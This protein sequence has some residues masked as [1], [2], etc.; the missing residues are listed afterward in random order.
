MEKAMLA[1]MHDSDDFFMRQLAPELGAVDD[2]ADNHSEESLAVDDDNAVVRELTLFYALRARQ[3]SGNF[4]RSL[5]KST[6]RRGVPLLSIGYVK[7]R[8]EILAWEAFQEGGRGISDEAVDAAWIVRL[9]ARLQ[10]QSANRR[11]PPIV[12]RGASLHGCLPSEPSTAVSSAASGSRDG[13]V[14]LGSGA[15]VLVDPPASAECATDDAEGGFPTATACYDYELLFYDEDEGEAGANPIARFPVGTKA[16]KRIEQAP[17]D[18]R[19]EPRYEGGFELPSASGGPMYKLA[20]CDATVAGAFARDYRT[21]QRVAALSRR[22]IGHKVT[23]EMVHGELHRLGRRP[24]RCCALVCLVLLAVLV[25]FLVARITILCM[26]RPSLGDCWPDLRQDFQ[27]GV[28][29]TKSAPATVGAEVCQRATGAIS[30]YDVQ[31]CLARDGMGVE[32]LKALL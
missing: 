6:V 27:L 24:A 19:E 13:D 18:E 2:A 25:N 4:M 3:C 7:D 32:C 16:L 5:V 30:F 23:T 1:D 20:F 17:E 10:A 15:V 12:Y 31:R 22:A 8:D 29:L 26:S 28:A 11:P 14:L 9:E 21:R